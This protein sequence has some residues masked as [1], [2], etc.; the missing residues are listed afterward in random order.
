MKNMQNKR[1]LI[2]LILMCLLL[3]MIACDLITPEQFKEEESFIS[4]FDSR[5]CS[6]LTRNLFPVDT[7]ISG[8]D[9]SIVKDTLYVEIEARIDS[10]TTLLDSLISDTIF[11]N[12]T[13]FSSLFDLI[14]DQ[15]EVVRTDTTNLIHCNGN[16]AYVY[17]PNSSERKLTVFV[18][19]E[20]NGLNVNDLVSIDFID[21]EGVF[22]SLDNQNMPIQT[23]SGCTMEYIV[24]EAT[25]DMDHTPAIK[26]R[27]SYNFEAQ[28]YLMRINVSQFIDGTSR[29]PLHIS[30]L[31]ND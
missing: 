22:A 11:T 20:F 9:T 13:E 10:L 21:S 3:S 30:L 7:L 5:A 14:S 23:V 6:F 24:D 4:D 29:V 17:F 27:T 25:G 8:G 28:P 16:S 2:K 26:T 31:Q 1:T 18:G 15:Q 19:W 12:P